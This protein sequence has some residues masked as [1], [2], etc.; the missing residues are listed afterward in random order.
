MWR[1]KS[2]SPQVE[3][4]RFDC[5]VSLKL[6]LPINVIAKDSK[7]SKIVCV[8]RRVVTSLEMIEVR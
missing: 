6:A 1:D 8:Y 3:L 2:D 4:I 7:Y 5:P